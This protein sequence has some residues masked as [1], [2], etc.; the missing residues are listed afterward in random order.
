MYYNYFVKII[1]HIFTFLLHFTHTK[2]NDILLFI[3]VFSHNNSTIY[4][5]QKNIHF[6]LRER[7]AYLSRIFFKNILKNINITFKKKFCFKLKIFFYKKKLYLFMF[8]YKNIYRYY[9]FVFFLLFCYNYETK[10]KIKRFFL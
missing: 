2:L 6:F 8:H 1:Y 5:K 3:M 10:V 9:K 7:D 4:K